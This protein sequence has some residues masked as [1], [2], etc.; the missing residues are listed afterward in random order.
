M[1][2]HPLGKQENEEGLVLIR[3]TKSPLQRAPDFNCE[4]GNCAE[5]PKPRGGW[6]APGG[7]VAYAGRDVSVGV[8]TCAGALSCHTHIFPQFQNDFFFPPIFFSLSLS[9]HPAEMWSILVLWAGP[10]PC[11]H[12]HLGF[13]KPRNFWVS[14]C[15]G[16]S[17][18]SGYLP[19]LGCWLRPSSVPG[20]FCLQRFACPCL[21]IH[22]LPSVHWAILGIL[23]GGHWALL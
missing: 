11:C 21:W 17:A 14:F 2:A 1:F 9:L 6:A 20:W 3:E 23:A 8:H 10:V 15:P 12:R 13:P 22:S 5:R 18:A 19:L 7:A 16:S 4:L